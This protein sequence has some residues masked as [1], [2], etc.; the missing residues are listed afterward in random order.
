ML[1]ALTEGMVQMEDAATAAAV[2]SLLNWTLIVAQVRVQ[3]TRLRP[4][5]SCTAYMR[6]DVALLGSVKRFEPLAL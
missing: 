2:A 3:C 4:V 6:S 1:L 5:L